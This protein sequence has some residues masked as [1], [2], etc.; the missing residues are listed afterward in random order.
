MDGAA[1]QLQW[2][3][4]LRGLRSAIGALDPELAPVEI[5]MT[6]RLRD[7]LGDPRRWTTVVGG[8]V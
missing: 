3:P 2:R 4:P 1:A 8:F 7:A 5:V 6:E